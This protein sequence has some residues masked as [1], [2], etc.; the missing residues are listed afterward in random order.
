MSENGLKKEVKE[1][2]TIYVVLVTVYVKSN[3]IC[4]TTIIRII[5]SNAFANEIQ[6]RPFAQLTL[7]YKSVLSLIYPK[8]RVTPLCLN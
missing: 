6:S 5:F 3:V 1:V 8:V 4:S 7:C 2:N